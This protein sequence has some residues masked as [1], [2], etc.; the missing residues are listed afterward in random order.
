MHTCLSVRQPWAVSIQL[1]APASG[2]LKK[3]KMLRLGLGVSIQL[4]APASGAFG[5]PVESFAGVLVSIQ[6]IA[7]AS[8]AY[9]K[10]CS[11][12]HLWRIEGFHSTDC[13]SEWGLQTILA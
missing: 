12:P 13:P 11:I 7:P 8:G 2:A 3:L 6:L 1:I 9:Q 5:L 10:K 4:I